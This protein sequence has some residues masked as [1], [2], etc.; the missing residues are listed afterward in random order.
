MS[1]QQKINPWN[2]ILANVAGGTTSASSVLPPSELID[3]AIR[4]WV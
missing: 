3:S 1:L 2:V 4:P